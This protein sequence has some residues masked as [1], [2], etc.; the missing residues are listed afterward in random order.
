MNEN[1]IIY[2]HINKINGKTYIGQ[3][4]Q[5]LSRRF[6][7][8]GEGYKNCPT[9][10]K[11]IQKY[12]W[13]NFKHIILFENLSLEQA[14]L[15]E[16]CLIEKF[17]LRN[18]LYGYNKDKGGRGIPQISSEEI[19]N[20]NK[21]NWKKGV[22]NNI[23]NKIYCIELNCSFESALEA[24]RETN[25]DNSSINKVCKKELNYAGLSPYGDPLHWIFEEDK[26]DELIK[27]LYFKKEI[28]KGIKIPIYCPELNQFFDSAADAERQLKID[29]SSIRKVIRGEKIT[30]GK[31]PDTKKPLHW[32][33]KKEFIK[34]KMPIEVWEKLKNETK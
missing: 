18:P 6:R 10:Y 4:K 21:E 9:F 30:A 34:N 1:Y 26:N 2:A 8:N 24:E 32:I 17:Q 22:Y 5:T 31:H 19:S 11:A 33:S 25:I 3:T 14:N 27:S 20:K 12:G 29:A 15:I 28:L 16:I 7:K 13:S 23:K